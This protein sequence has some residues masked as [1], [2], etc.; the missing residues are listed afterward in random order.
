METLV[1]EKVNGRRIARA[2]NCDKASQSTYTLE[3]ASTCPHHQ[4]GRHDD[5]FKHV[6]QGQKRNV[7]LRA[8]KIDAR[9]LQNG[10]GI[11]NNVLVG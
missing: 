6:S 8:R 2:M 5:A 3:K 9:H 10:C 11:A 4:N 7:S 1:K